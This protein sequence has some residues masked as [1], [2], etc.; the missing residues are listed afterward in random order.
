MNASNLNMSGIEQSKKD[1]YSTPV[2]YMAKFTGE[3]TKNL[4][5]AAGILIG[6]ISP[7]TACAL[8][9]EASHLGEIVDN[10]IKN[11]F[12]KI[13]QPHEQ[14]STF[15]NQ[16]PPIEVILDFD[17]V[18]LDHNFRKLLKIELESLNENMKMYNTQLTE[19]TN[20]DYIKL[21]NERAKIADEMKLQVD[22]DKM[23]NSTIAVINAM[24]AIAPPE[25]AKML[26]ITSSAISIGSGFAGVGAL[27]NIHPVGLGVMALCLVISVSGML[28]DNN[29]IDSNYIYFTHIMS[30]IKDIQQQLHAIQI[31]LNS[32][33]D[34]LEKQLE[35]VSKTLNYA[36][37]NVKSQLDYL[38]NDQH[39]QSMMI[40]FKL[41]A[42]SNQINS[43]ELILGNGIKEIQWRPIY[44]MIS[45]YQQYNIRFGVT[46]ERRDLLKILTTIESA[47][48]NPPM[49]DFING[50]YLLQ[51]SYTIEVDN[52]VINLWSNLGFLTG[53]SL[54]NID[55]LC[56]LLDNYI[57]IRMELINQGIVYDPN[58]IIRNKIINYMKQFGTI[59]F[60]AE[61]IQSIVLNIIETNNQIKMITDNINTQQSE[62]LIHMRL[63]DE[64][65]EP[66]YRERKDGLHLAKI[67]YL[68]CKGADSSGNYG[69]SQWIINDRELQELE[70]RR[71][72]TLVGRKIIIKGMPGITGF[73]KVD[74]TGCYD[75]PIICRNSSIFARID[76]QLSTY[77]QAEKEGYGKLQFHYFVNCN[78]LPPGLHKIAIQM[79]DGFTNIYGVDKIESRTIPKNAVCG[80]YLYFTFTIKCLWYS[81]QTHKTS[82]LGV[83]TS[84]QTKSTRTIDK[85]FIAT[86]YRTDITNEENQYLHP[87][88]ITK[89]VNEEQ[90]INSSVFQFTPN[91]SLTAITQL[92]AN[93]ISSAKL[94]NNEK[95]MIATQEHYNVIR[96]GLK[97]LELIYTSNDSDDNTLPFTQLL[98]LIS[99]N[100]LGLI[101]VSYKTNYDN[102]IHLLLYFIGSIQTHVHSRLIQLIEFL[103]L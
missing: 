53:K 2:C 52:K 20:K 22:K 9:F 65:M 64:L 74:A 14:P 54:P 75:L 34:N 16:D 43:M 62:I 69:I 59:T 81:N 89:Y 17:Y 91:S 57:Q 33:F 5:I 36:I 42:I 90:L 55:M 100:Y 40:N 60:D 96:R 78:E 46:M 70:F 24:T 6:E 83:F 8:F 97:Q 13:T 37:Y 88:I 51:K 27:A 4:A 12:G 101:D 67:N 63:D 31:Q 29:G 93:K 86:L 56:D 30:A 72:F 38:I 3:L 35:Q 99:N 66:F 28:D 11:Y 58:M 71:Q 10:K 82:E 48:I 68:D 39:R 76:S 77:I 79:Y 15:K 49:L 1:G 19:N 25:F 80:Q 18:R 26:A 102:K 94:V 23:V 50:H 95:I 87:Y 7:I 44:E 41:N 84:N 32:R 61:Y 21:L 47:I 98:K 85:N 103:S 92:Y 45:D 73:N